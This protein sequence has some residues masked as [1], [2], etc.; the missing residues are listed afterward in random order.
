MIG[1]DVDDFALAPDA[2]VHVDRAGGKDDPPL[3]FTKDGQITRLATP[4]ID[5]LLLRRS[6]LEGDLRHRRPPLQTND[7]LFYR[8]PGLLS[9]A[10]LA[11]FSGLAC[12][13]ARM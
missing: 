6:Q 1:D 8:Q 3:A 9:H 2:A 5:A 11:T 7:E 13:M 4:I 10:A 12:S